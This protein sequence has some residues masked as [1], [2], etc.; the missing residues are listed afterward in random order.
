MNAN[1]KK[2]AVTAMLTALAY[3]VTLIIR[4]PFPAAPFLTYDPKDVFIIIGGFLFGPFTV[5]P[6]SAVLSL[7]EMPISGTGPIG[8]I[9]NMVSTCA[10]A[11]PAAAVYKF[12]RTIAGA[13][14]GISLGVV[15]AASV[16]MPWNYILTPLYTQAPRGAVLGMLL[17]VLLPFNLLK[18]IYNAA[19]TM[20][21]Y[22]R[23]S[24]II[25]KLGITQLPAEKSGAKLAVTVTALVFA[26]ITGVLFTLV[27]LGVM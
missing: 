13:A 9:M 24:V 26:V 16:M 19:I 27:V 14:V 20:L 25:K 4:A 7:L 21:V 8:F 1:I 12:N 3:I 11:F 10:F 15:F 18:G 22:K 2:L 6:M 17:P 23:L 5:F